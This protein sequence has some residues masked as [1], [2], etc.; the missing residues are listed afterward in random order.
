MRALQLLIAVFVSLV[1]LPAAAV[2][3]AVVE[4][5]QAPAWLDRNGFTSPL[6]PGME[7]HSG[8]VL[9][10]GAGARAYVMLAEGSRV[11]LGESARFALYS[12]SV[13][14]RKYFRGA[15]DVLAGAF[16]YTTGYVAK[17]RKRE[18]S[19]RVST[20]TI[21]IR[22]TDIWGKTDAQGEFIALLDGRID[23][24]RAGETTELALPMTYFDAPRGQPA[25]VK[26]LD[27]ALMKTLAR[28]TEIEAGD[29]A[30]RVTGSWRAMAGIV[31]SNAA[32]L[33]LYDRINEAGFG[34][35]IR[36]VATDATAAG[37]NW[38]YEVALTGFADE[39]EA[40][41]A[42]IRLKALTGLEAKVMR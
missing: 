39:T 25:V 10:T 35:R 11:K 26:P 32:A 2:S 33:E 38:S 24:T 18:L 12:R 31:P 27:A 5:V 34:A 20:A 7:L 40:Q 3:P 9:R 42:S 28:Q 17:D 16:R 23:I 29:G 13:D 4:A 41:R 30:A 6:V 37:K 15:L 1:A 14:P 19:I 21:G 8:D 36:P 22:G